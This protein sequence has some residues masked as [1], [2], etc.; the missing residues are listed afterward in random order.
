MARILKW[1]GALLAL[2]VVVILGYAGYIAYRFEA[3]KPAMEGEAR[4]EGP[5][6]AVDIVR[7]RYGIPH[8]FGASETDVYFGLG[9]AH[10]QD[11]FFQMDATRRAMQGRLSELIGPRTLRMDARARTMGWSDVA[12]RQFE[13]LK[14]EARAI[15]NAYSAGVNAR[16]ALGNVA[17]EYGLFLGKP[18][19]WKPVDSMAVSLAMTDLLTGGEEDDAAIAR[20]AKKLSAEQ[21]ESFLN[22]Y[23]AYGAVSYHTGDLAAS[24]P[25]P[26]RKAG[27]ER[28]APGSNAWVVSGARS[29]TGRPILAN[30]PHLG[31]AAPGPFYLTRLSLPSGPLV[32]ATLP[33]APFVVIGR[34]ARIA[35]GT[36]THAIDAADFVVLSQAGEAKSETATIRIRNFFVFMSER[37]VDIRRTS[38]G[39]VL[40]PE[41]FAVDDLSEEPLV[42]R[43]IAD[44]ADNGLANAVLDITRAES[45]DAFLA[46]VKPWT[47]PPQNLVVASV[48]GDIGL[49]SPGRFPARDDTGAWVGEIP[50]TA[51]LA[52]KNPARG[53]F[54]TANNLQTPQDYPYPM[55]GGHDPYRV[56]RISEVLAAEAKHDKLRAAAL[57]GDKRS[58][59]ARRLV[60]RI[61][62]AEAATPAGRAMQAALAA[63]DGEAR[64]D[65]VEAT[66]FAYFTRALADHLYKDEL[67]DDL[68]KR[69]LGPR[70]EFL[71]AALTGSASKWC[72]DVATATKED[73]GFVIAAALD[74]AAN[75]LVRER[76]ADPAGWTWG[77]VH[78]A[79]FPHALFSSLPLIGDRFTVEVP[80]G[81]NSTTVSVARNWHTNPHYHTV[82]AAGM[83]FI[84]DMAD[85]DASWFALAPGQSGHPGSRHYGDLAKL[86]AEHRYFEIRTDWGPSAKPA[87]TTTWR[88][89]PLH[90]TE[91]KTP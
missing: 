6:A 53:W 55:P 75:D 19:P 63:W 22:P 52:A 12:Q 14:P 5:S 60:P 36:T 37:K 1:A 48:D 25:A 91:E 78:A 39:P 32:G 13:G 88:L 50:V 58:F 68:F 72:D 76:G 27:A 61:A 69:F 38:F 89:T 57:Q 8:V 24:G 18:E 34:N 87:D 81:G 17:P 70:E 65:G 26:K 64:A 83:R 9:F 82:H 15:L 66:Q 29:G 7:D 47:A 33:G 41:W 3:T 16:L 43:T 77:E 54:A 49:V 11:R 4:V 86:W 46:A 42:L 59:L 71:D 62:E 28:T 31:L 2:G 51:R 45:V 79:R 74:T 67:G 80:F 40:D 10:A 56:T 90:M 35:W 21:I 85:P 44:D 84:A 23:P 20:L 73:C 30:D